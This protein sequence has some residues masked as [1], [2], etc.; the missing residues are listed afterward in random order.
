MKYILPII[1]AALML[2]ACSKE[3]FEH[4]KAMSAENFPKQL[5]LDEEEIGEL[6]DSDEVK[7]EIRLT[8]AIDPTGEELAGKVSPLQTGVVVTFELKDPE[9]FA[10]WNEYIVD[11]KAYYE[12]DDCTTSEDENIDLGYTFDP[13]TGQGS[14]LFPAGVESIV[15]ELELNASL[16]DD[17]LE[18]A[19]DRG[20]NFALKSLGTTPENVVLNTDIE[21][22]FRV[23]DDEK[24]FG[25]WSFD[26][27]DATQYQR[28]LD[29]FRISSEDLEGLTADE[30]DEVE[31][32]FAFDE[33]VLKLVLAETE[34]QEECGIIEQVNIEISIEGEID[35]LTDDSTSGE[36]VFVVEV[37]NENGTVTEVEYEGTFERTGDTLTLTLKGDNGDE[38]TEELVLTLTK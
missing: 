5:I 14:V 38:E 8:D 37:E 20:F 11:G 30:I 31:A 32:S 25:D 26:H 1:V 18:N 6:E 33:F 27:T 28:L 7:F 34:E 19:D 21:S 3:K 15:I 10:N 4:T 22:E 23:Y 35:N 24:V 12:I 2:G 29:L 13:V 16:T 36:I 17:V 9:G